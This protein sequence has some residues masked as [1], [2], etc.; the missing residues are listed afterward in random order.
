MDFKSLDCL[1]KPLTGE[2]ILAKLNA[3]SFDNSNK[4]KKTVDSEECWK[5]KSIFFEL[6]Y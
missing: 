3:M 6:E 5:K 4:R 1:P 2:E